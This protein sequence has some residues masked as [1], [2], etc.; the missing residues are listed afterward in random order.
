[1]K[2]FRKNEEYFYN[3]ADTKKKFYCCRIT[4]VGEDFALAV[5]EKNG[6]KVDGSRV[7]ITDF[8]EDE[9]VKKESPLGK[10][11]SAF[12][13]NRETMKELNNEDEDSFE[14]G[15]NQ[16]MVYVLGEYGLTA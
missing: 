3:A 13:S 16:A 2:S 12:I 5:M 11:I 9:F 1:M 4:D 15:Y 8:N 14:N 7:Y 10:I 6:E